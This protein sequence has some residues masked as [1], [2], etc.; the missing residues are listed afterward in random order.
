MDH[1]HGGHGGHEGHDMPGMEPMCSMNMVFNWDTQNVCVLF[2]SWRINSVESLLV[3]CLA[4]IALSAGYELTKQLIRR[5][6][7][8]AVRQGGGATRR[9][10]RRNSDGDDMDSSS[11]CPAGNSDATSTRGTT[12][13]GWTNEEDSAEDAAETSR[14]ARDQDMAIRVQGRG[15]GERSA[16]K[17]S[18][19]NLRVT[20]S[21]LYS[22]QVFY[23]FLLMLIFMTYNWYLVI[24]VVVGT[25]IGHYFFAPDEMAGFRSMSCH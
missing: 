13:P 22:L 18:Q 15:Q 1:D 20:R 16:P 4:I 17:K 11:R 8:Y 25:A 19:T 24:S 21:A 12:T 9:R 3:S 2:D 14:L 5:W 10:R 6:E 23:S 7:C